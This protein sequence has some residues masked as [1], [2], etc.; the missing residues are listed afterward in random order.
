MIDIELVKQCYQEFKENQEYYQKIDKYYYGNTDKLKQVNRKKWQ[1]DFHCIDNFF[2]TFVDQESQYSFGNHPTYK[3]NAEESEN[4]AS[5]IKYYVNNNSTYDSSLGQR[6]VEL[7]LVYEL[8]FIG[9]D[10]FKNK[11]ITPLEGN[12]A[13]DEYDEP[14]FFIY[15]HTKRVLDRT[16][17]PNKYVLVD[18]I[19][20]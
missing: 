10:G 16:V 1:S 2:Q 9:K 4:V 12:M 6:L 5:L 13:F 14:M 7:G 15:V 19:D 18:Y 11:I 3:Y 20:V 8:S 17:Q